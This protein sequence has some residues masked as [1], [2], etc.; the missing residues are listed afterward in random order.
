MLHESY[1]E[2]QVENKNKE[3]FE[4]LF[5]KL[6]YVCQLQLAKEEIQ[7]NSAWCNKNMMNY[8][9]GPIPGFPSGSWWGIRMDCSRDRVHDPFDDNIQNGP[10]GVTSV[11][12]SS[13]NINEDVDFGNSL[14]LTGQ[15]YLDG[16]SD[17][18][19]L[20]INYE[21]QIPIRLIRSYNLLNEF[22]PKTG[23]RYDGLYIVTKFWVGL[24]SDST[25]Y[26]KFAL[27]RLNGQEPP[28]WNTKQ[29]SPITS[30]N[31]SAPH[32]ATISLRNHSENLSPGSIVQKMSHEK[33]NGFFQ[34]SNSENKQT[35]EKEK[36]VSESV[37]VTRHVFKKVN[38]ECT[39]TTP[40]MSNASENKSL[41][42]IGNQGS[43]THSTNISIRTGLY[44]SSHS[45]QHDV[46][47]SNLLPSCRT[48]KS[49][50]LLKNNQ[51]TEHLNSSSKDKSKSL[52][53]KAQSITTNELPKRVDYFSPNTVKPDACKLKSSK[54]ANIEVS[55]G[56]NDTNLNHLY[57]YEC[58][59]SK[60]HRSIATYSENKHKSTSTDTSTSKLNSTNSIFKTVSK[61]TQ[62]L[63]SLNSL[64]ALTPDTILHLINKKCHPLSKLL[65]GNMIGLTSEQ[66]VELKPQDLLTVQ[67]E[68]IDKISMQNNASEETNEK[69]NLDTISDDLS[70]YKYRRHKK[71]S[72]KT[73]NKS[74]IR[75]YG[76]MHNDES[77]K[78]SVNILGQKMIF[79]AYSGAQKNAPEDVFD[80]DD[81]KK[82]VK[83]KIMKRNSIQKKK[84]NCLRQSSKT[85]K[86]DVGIKNEIRTRLRTMKTIQS[87]LNKHMN[88]KKRREIANLLIDAKIG[89]KIRGPRNRR[90]RCI[91][92]TY[93]KK[94]YE[95]CTLNNC[96]INAK[97]SE[98]Q[99]SFKDKNNLSKIN[100]H[101][102]IKE[103]QDRE[104]QSKILNLNKTKIRK[105]LIVSKK[106]EKYDMAERI[107]ENK[108]DI[109]KI[110]K[111]NK[112]SKLLNASIKNIQSKDVIMTENRRRKLIRTISTKV[113]LN[114]VEE[115]LS[116]NCKRKDLKPC[117]ADAV[118]QCSLIKEPLMRSLKS[119]D[120][121]QNNN[122]NGQYTF[123]KIKY[124]K[125][126]S[127]K[128]EACGVTR[129]NSENQ[130]NDKY[131][132][133]YTKTMCN[134]PYLK[135][136]SIPFNSNIL[137]TREQNKSS[138]KKMSA[139]VP[140][141]TLDS[142]LKI[143]RLRSIGFKPIESSDNSNEDGSD[144]NKGNCS[145]TFSDETL[146]QNVSEKY[147]KYANEEDDIVVYMDDKLQYQD[148][149]DEDSNLSNTK[150]SLSEFEAHTSNDEEIEIEEDSYK[151]A[152]YNDPLLEQDLELPW[153]GWKQVVTSE[154]TYWIGW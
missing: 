41:A 88:R 31:T 99:S 127:T 97:I 18:D 117:K 50:N 45:T 74:E 101:K 103:N 25:K 131:N 29:S 114:R 78:D 2:S 107:L 81:C 14:T 28:P 129:S 8:T 82:D 149:E 104:K 54:D 34:L 55:S 30:K 46:K 113:K 152:L 111:S 108:H 61:E 147:N 134:V 12:T 64:D 65:M 148:I 32:S 19:P 67:S 5:I 60:T 62:E 141:N 95:C 3:D 139:F 51:H 125:C 89:P 4:K 138:V 144:Q 13:T 96:Q 10:F 44:D 57:K 69:A 84:M 145:V 75:N 59:D 123:I 1:C 85:I 133:R 100:R 86:K 136:S 48:M 121:V 33:S 102:R 77:Q 15:K 119:E 83:S 66:S 21:C 126:K 128:S 70:V 68:I 27:M 9:Y 37:I 39:S 109:N 93:S 132:E 137:S 6:N 140:V 115:T 120:I 43:K 105:N 143:A 142:D 26:Y 153:H 56:T 122:R 40:S 20:T 71:L 11:C 154:N 146:K 36:S 42:H 106:P 150:Q 52:D 80:P 24:N 76:K 72:R 7:L 98:K 116:Q 35:D 130:S 92:N 47:K 94:S 87:S 22:A 38:T 110:R 23:Y 112:K 151:K 91:S 135:N 16:K 63:K 90:L 53:G 17:K 118:T 79:N 58:D 124:G 73:M 49:L